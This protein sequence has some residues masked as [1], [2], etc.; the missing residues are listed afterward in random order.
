VTRRGSA[1]KRAEHEARQA[2]LRHVRA[3]N[4]DR[5]NRTEDDDKWASHWAA[6]DVVF[7]LMDRRLITL[8]FIQRL[9]AEI[10]VAADAEIIAMR[11]RDY[12]ERKRFTEQL[13]RKE[14]ESRVYDFATGKPR[15]TLDWFERAMIDFG[16]L[17][18]NAE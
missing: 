13:R 12:L 2:F 7:D 9:N 14:Q 15:E 8:E 6:Y 16:A 17:D 3:R 4:I 11:R 5:A 1:S 18:E 10:G